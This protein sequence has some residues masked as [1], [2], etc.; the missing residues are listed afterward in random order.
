MCRCII[1]GVD[2]AIIIFAVLLLQKHNGAETN[3]TGQHGDGTIESQT[4]LRTTHT[5][6]QQRANIYHFVLIAALPLFSP[7]EAFIR[8]KRGTRINQM[9]ILQQPTLSTT[10]N[11]TTKRTRVRCARHIKHKSYPKRETHQPPSHKN[12]GAV[13]TRQSMKQGG[14]RANFSKHSRK[15]WIGRVINQCLHTTI[16]EHKT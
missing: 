3:V 13:N 10:G 4:T 1:N 11:G 9:F 2:E 12:S 7:D 14:N 6:S 15:H 16:R 8:Q 5:W